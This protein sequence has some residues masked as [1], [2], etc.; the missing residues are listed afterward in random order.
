[1][2]IV[3]GKLKGAN[4]NSKVAETTRPTSDSIRESIF[5]LLQTRFDFENANIADLYAGT[6]ALG[7]EA[8]S[9]GAGKICF[10]ESNKK[11]CQVIEANIG[12]VIRNFDESKNNFVLFNQPVSVFIK[13]KQNAEYFDLILVD[14]PYDINFE[15]DI[16]SI[17]RPG[18]LVVYE[19]TSKKLD[20]SVEIFE[21]IESVDEVLVAR[22]M[23]NSAV[24]IFSVC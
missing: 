8:Y 20:E 14:P 12:L 1:M 17:V 5:N 11:A 24:I 6:G 2:R 10:V 4:L 9:R 23:G 3:A 7:L 16:I 18:G 13:N 22:K 15:I 21:N 19:T